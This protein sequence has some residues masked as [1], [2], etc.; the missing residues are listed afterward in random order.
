MV[1]GLNPQYDSL[2]MTYR[3]TFIVLK[4]YYFLFGTWSLGTILV[5]GMTHLLGD[6]IV[7]ATITYPHNF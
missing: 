4:A 7:T 2:L 3:H 1:P 5:Y 6:V